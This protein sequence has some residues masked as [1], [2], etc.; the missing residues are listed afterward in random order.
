MLE[1]L[2]RQRR[3]ADMRPR[4]EH[5]KRLG[6]VKLPRDARQSKRGEVDDDVPYL[7]PV[8]SLHGSVIERPPRPM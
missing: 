6:E 8:I 2:Q 4:V 7:K 1:Q 3:L 5:Q